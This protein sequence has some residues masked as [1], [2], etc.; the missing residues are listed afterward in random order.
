MKEL[1][2]KMVKKLIVPIGT[3]LVLVLLIIFGG[4]FMWGQISQLRTQ[5]KLSRSDEAKLSQKLNVLRNFEVRGALSSESLS[6][7]L[8]EANPTVSAISQ[9]KNIA[10]QNGVFIS[11]FGVGKGINSEVS[12]VDINFD[13]QAQILPLVTMFTD[14]LKSAPL[15][16]INKVE[17]V[18]NGD[19]AVSNVSYRVYYSELPKT[20]P[21]I[22]EQLTEFTTEDAEII[23]KLITLI[24][25][26]FVEVPAQGSSPNSNPFG[27]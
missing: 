11:D 13:A 23:D 1:N 16:S 9:I 26:I 7:S 2:Y 25:P 14:L 18:Q 17:I 15:G 21:T 5:L 24:P 22:L 12:Y 8:P 6:H 10:N 3:I 20:L 4:Q 27:L 19:I